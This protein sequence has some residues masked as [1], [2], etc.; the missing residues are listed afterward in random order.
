MT[1]DTLASQTPGSAVQETSR[2]RSARNIKYEPLGIARSILVLAYIIVSVWYPDY[3]STTFN[4]QAMTLSVIVYAAEWFG[5]V[6]SLM[7]NY[8]VLLL[9][10]R[11]APPAPVGLR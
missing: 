5:I 10:V 9:T 4:P 6:V 3:R 7:H 8:M 2:T 1:S 11:Y